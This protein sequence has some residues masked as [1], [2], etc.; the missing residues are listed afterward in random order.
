MGYDVTDGL[1][2]SIRTLCPQRLLPVVVMDDPS[3]AEPLRE[4]LQ[5]GGLS[6]AEITLRTSDAL[7]A[8]YAMAEDPDFIVGAGTVLTPHQVARAHAVGARF[9]VSPGYSRLV[10]DECRAVGLPFFPGVATSTEI[11]QALEA[12]LR[13]LK[14]FPAE[15]LGG[16]GTLKTL[17]APFRDVAFIPTGGITAATASSYL[18]LPQVAAVGGSWIAS[19]ALLRAGDFASIARLTGEAVRLSRPSV[20]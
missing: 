13:E 20:T 4:A 8:V 15:S 7:D 19:E 6:C 3:G 11:Q 9:I 16:P 1:A 12:G 5:A 10:A 2:T 14:F 17:T 18:A